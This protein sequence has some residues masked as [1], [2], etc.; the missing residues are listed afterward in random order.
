M[1]NGFGWL[2]EKKSGEVVM[3]RVGVEHGLWAYRV[4]NE[5]AG[6]ALRAHPTNSSA[7]SLKLDSDVIYPHGYV[8]WADARVADGA[9]T[10]VRV[11]GTTGWLFT[12]REGCETLLPLA[13]FPSEAPTTTLT[14]API[15]LQREERLS[16]EAVREVAARMGL[17]EIQYNKASRII[18]FEKVDRDGSTARINVYYT[19][20]TVGTAL[21]HPRQGKTQMF[22][23]NCGLREVEEIMANPRVHTDKGYKRCQDI[24]GVLGESDHGDKAKRLKSGEGNALAVMAASAAAA[25]ETVP[26]TE[27]G[28]V[29]CELRELDTALA[30]M[31]EQ[32]AGLVGHL[33][34]VEGAARAVAT[35][36]MED[37]LKKAAALR[38]EAARHE[39]EV[40]K[41]AAETKRRALEASRGT[42]YTYCIAHRDDVE[43]MFSPR[44]ACV[45]MGGAAT[46]MLYDNGSFTYT[47][48][49]AEGI[50][51]KLHT[52][53]ASHPKPAY[54]AL[55]SQ[56]RYYVNFTNGKSEWSGPEYL[57]DAIH[58]Q[59]SSPVCVA[60]GEEWGSYFVLFGNGAYE[61]QNV[62][63]G[64][65]EF[66]N[67]KRV[68][69]YGVKWVSLGPNG[70][71]FIE[72]NSGNKQWGGMTADAFQT[73]KRDTRGGMTFLE[74]GCN[75][76]WFARYK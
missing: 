61:S 48:G 9:T 52:R 60:F 19:T 40:A 63:S 71:Y 31:M 64:L 36:A 70:E 49:L 54:V 62:P 42:L 74:F 44:V 47:G 21:Q 26:D 17:R 20:G 50:H 13:N 39:A 69:K 23:R 68:K 59:T 11:Q 58:G 45:A 43:N 46:L 33:H 57:G 75:G 27:E 56:E 76:T 4:N 12:H 29:R 8:V 72:D 30:I 37:A 73:I 41:Q 22:R 25:G 53:A 67:I 38:A 14:A 15:T 5:E 2:F 1:S 65:K 51:K 55:G 35:T 6:L 66:L 34:E 3:Q 7:A 28:S 18:A 32:R 10:Y 24:T 16:A